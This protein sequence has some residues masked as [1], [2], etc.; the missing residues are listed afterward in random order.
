MKRRANVTVDSA[1][2]AEAKALGINLSQ[3]L[4]TGLRDEMARRWLDE[5]RAAIESFNKYVNEHGTM[6]DRMRAIERTN[7]LAIQKAPGLA[8]DDA[9]Y[10]PQRKSRPRAPSR[11]GAKTNRKGRV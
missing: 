11:S 9:R 4:E 6:G 2:L 5:N 8:E 7:P 3:T 10:K 1:L